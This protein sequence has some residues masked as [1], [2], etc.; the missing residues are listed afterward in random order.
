MYRLVRKNDGLIKTSEDVCYLSYYKDGRFK[1]RHRAPKKGRVLWMSPFKMS[2]TWMTTEITE[3]IEQRVDY[4]HFKT[5][6]SE[7]ELFK[8]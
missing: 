3:V 2:F 4:V 7:Y 6:N 5:I 8:E 1:G